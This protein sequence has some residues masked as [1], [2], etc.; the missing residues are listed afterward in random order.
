MWTKYRKWRHLLGVPLL[1]L[2]YFL[3]KTYPEISPPWCVGLAIG[4]L[5]GGAYV[6][7]ELVWTV[8]GRG[9]PCGHC[10]QR[11]QLKSFSV[12]TD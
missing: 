6:V 3:L 8:R 11:I 1:A 10:G 2:S 4:S 5:F 9:R 7:E 12:S